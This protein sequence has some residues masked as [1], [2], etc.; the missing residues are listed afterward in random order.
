M[1]IGTLKLAERAAVEGYAI[2]PAVLSDSECDVLLHA[3]QPRSLQ[4]SNRA[5]VR[6]LLRDYQE[7]RALAQLAAIRS[8]AAAVLGGPGY[9][10]R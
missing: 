4:A 6:S 7:V 2:V 5:G 3:L 1:S 9:H 10:V 8:L